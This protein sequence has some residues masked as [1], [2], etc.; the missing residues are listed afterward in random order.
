MFVIC[1]IAK[2]KKKKQCYSSD[3]ISKAQILRG[4][5]LLSVAGLKIIVS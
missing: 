4:K 2:K 3:L 1:D 5:I